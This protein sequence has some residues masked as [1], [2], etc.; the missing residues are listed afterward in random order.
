VTCPF[1]KAANPDTATFCGGCGEFFA[2]SLEPGSVLA[3]RYEVRALVGRG[4]MGVVYRAYDRVLDDEIALKVLRP[5]AKAADLA[6][7]I[8]SEIKLARHIRHP[9]VCA[10]HDYGEDGQWRFISMEL[11]E[12][13]DLK[14]IIRDR[15]AFSFGEG[16]EIALQVAAGLA[17]VHQAGIIHRDL[18]AANI[19]LDAAG[20]VRLMDFG[21]ARRVTPGT[22]ASLTLSGQVVGSPEYMSPE[23]ARGEALDARSDIYSL[24]VVLFE[25]FGGKVPFQGD[26]PVATILKHLQEPPPLEPERRGRVPEAICPVL[27][28]ALAKSREDRYGS[29]SEMAAAIESARR[30][31]VRLG[32]TPTATQWRSALPPVL[33]AASPRQSPVRRGAA[34]VAAVVALGATVAMVAGRAPRMP[35][36]DASPPPITSAPVPTP[37]AQVAPPGNPSSDVPES[38]VPTV[39]PPPPTVAPRREA[40]RPAPATPWSPL[41]LDIAEPAKEAAILRSALPPATVS[42]TIAP[43]AT[44]VPPTTLAAPGTL[45]L[46]VVP[47]ADVEIDGVKAG[48]TPFP[49]VSLAPGRHVVRLVHPDYHPLR[50]EVVIA[51]GVSARLSVDFTWEGFKRNQ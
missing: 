40:A 48:Q 18:K 8:R 17:A 5:D 7:R 20:T 24:G 15:G 42:A 3:S 49:P 1:C 32:A 10:I 31:S 47:W 2:L 12:G 41:P 13:H 51:S 4:G 9:N 33:L 38:P 45:K 36:A 35:I 43:P 44:T 34:A 14:Q 30:E 50:R 21:I 19:M 37:T 26:T 46:S 39:A 25:V 29:V 6:K 16:C 27:R 22:T 28:K 23:Q 11:I